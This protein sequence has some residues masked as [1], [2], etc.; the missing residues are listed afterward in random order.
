MKNFILKLYLFQEVNLKM[1][2]F[3]VTSKVQAKEVFQKLDV[4][5]LFTESAELDLITD[6]KPIGISGISHE[7]V[8]E[9]NVNGTEGAAATG[10]NKKNTTL[11]YLLNFHLFLRC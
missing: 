4:K 7:S 3:K 1:P 8:I 5:Q 6:K 11:F 10:N 2:P 9:V